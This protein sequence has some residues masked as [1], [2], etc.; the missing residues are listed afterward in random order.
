[1]PVVPEVEGAFGTGRVRRPRAHLEVGS[2]RGPAIDRERR[3][4]LNVIVGYA[5]GVAGSAIA[6]VVTRIVPCN[7]NE[8]RGLVDRDR[9]I[10]LAVRPSV[11]VQP[12]CQDPRRT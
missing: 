11:V 6:Q 10:D 7:P 8:A 1:M 4:E 3:P 5:V 2:E 12:D 9:R